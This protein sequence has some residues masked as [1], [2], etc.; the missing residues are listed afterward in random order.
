M[1]S[2]TSP[3]GGEGEH[4]PS[5]FIYHVVSSII[6]IK[7]S[8]K[9]GTF[10]SSNP[11]ARACDEKITGLLIK[12]FFCR[13]LSLLVSPSSR[14]F[15]GKSLVIQSAYGTMTTVEDVPPI[16]YLSRECPII[17]YDLSSLRL[18]CVVSHVDCGDMS[19]MRRIHR[20]IGM[21]E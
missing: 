18:K 8:I 15:R 11:N 20:R 12:C 2:Q 1:T 7:R 13:S 10:G 3:V 21:R 16:G 14:R 6:T 19:A 4:P 5:F 17:Q 9:I